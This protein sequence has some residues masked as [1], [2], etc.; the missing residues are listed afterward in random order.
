MAY[1]VKFLKGTADAYKALALKDENTFYFTSDDGQLYLGEVQLSNAA[2]L[3][4]AVSRVATNESDIASIKNAIG[5]L[6]GEGFTDL[7]A[8]V[9]ANEGN[10]TTL[11]TDVKANKDAL[12]I[13]NGEATVAGSVKK[14]VADAVAKIVADAP[15]AYDTLKEISDW[16]SSHGSDAS[17]MNTAI[18]TNTTNIQNLTKLLG[19]L[20]DGITATDFAGYI[21]EAVKAE[22]TRATGVEGGFET[23]IAALEGAVGETGSVTSAIATAKQEAIDAAATDAT[24][25]AN[26]A[27]AAAEKTAA[28]DATTKANTAETNAKA[29]ADGLASNYAT[30]EQGAKADTA[31]QEVKTGTE[32]GTIAVDGTNVAVKGLGTAAYA[33]TG[34][35][36]AAGAASTAETNAKAYTDTALTWQ[37]IS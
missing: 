30:A 21:K 16:I 15:E 17:A 37:T 20:P 12:D 9:A 11:Q 31:V 7:E 1:N 27:Q 22:E 10:I 18:G 6:T 24:S 35:F 19:S 26:A 28:A 3:A 36:D 32:N 29:Y 34:D 2:A 8:R 33:A 13:L 5:S 4:A 14:Q 23:R 25:K